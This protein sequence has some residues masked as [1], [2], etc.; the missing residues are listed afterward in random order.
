M[1]TSSGLRRQLSDWENNPSHRHGRQLALSKAPSGAK[2]RVTG[3]FRQSRLEL[4]HD[5]TDARRSARKACIQNR[6]TH[7]RNGGQEIGPQKTSRT[8]V[9]EKTTLKTVPGILRIANAVKA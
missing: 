4:R 9:R 2:I 8:A 5:E 7:P 6:L 1:S 3:H